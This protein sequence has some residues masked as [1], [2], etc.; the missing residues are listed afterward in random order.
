L[1]RESGMDEEFE[2]LENIS[3]RCAFIV[4]SRPLVP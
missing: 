3:F 1:V 2:V 4:Y